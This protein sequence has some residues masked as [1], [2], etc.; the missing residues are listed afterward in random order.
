MRLRFTHVRSGGC[1]RAHDRG[2]RAVVD[3]RDGSERRRSVDYDD[4]VPQAEH[5]HDDAAVDHDHDHEASGHDHHDVSAARPRRRRRHR[6]RPRRLRS[7]SRS[8]RRTTTT[9]APSHVVNQPNF[10]ALTPHIVALRGTGVQYQSSS[11]VT[12]QGI[13]AEHPQLLELAGRPVP[14]RLQGPRHLDARRERRLQACAL[15]RVP[16]SGRAVELRR[17]RRR[18]I[19]ASG[20]Q[21]RPARASSGRPSSR[22]RAGRTNPRSARPALP[23]ATHANGTGAVAE[24]Y[25]AHVAATVKLLSQ[26]RDLHPARHAPGRLQPELPR[27]GRSRLGRVHRQRADRA[28]GRPVVE[29]LLEPDPADGGRRTSG[30]TTWWATCRA[31]TT[32]SGRRW[33]STS[34]TIR[35]VVGL[36]PLQRAVLDRD[37]DGVGVDVHRPAGVLLHRQGPH[38]LPGQRDG[39][40]DLPVRRSRTTA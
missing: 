31:T 37:P 19:A 2:V 14:L 29:Q 16:R 15:H 8:V 9:T 18:Q 30:A 26:L 4:R 12:S 11:G 7:R 13:G 34:R 22:D 39:A 23:E 17:D 1:C 35:W 21:R 36:R 24:Q 28:Q 33:P 3:E 25:L 32:W 10:N 6:P 40:A 20:L 38:R 5:D 27:R